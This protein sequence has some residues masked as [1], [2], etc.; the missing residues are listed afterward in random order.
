MT[1]L[2]RRLA[3]HTQT[4]ADVGESLG[5]GGGRARD[6]SSSNVK[7]TTT[8]DPEQIITD[9][10]LRSGPG[11]AEQKTISYKAKAKHITH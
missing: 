9:G 11:G 7:L 6:T 1:E 10:P 5:H 8:S 2:L 4:S 3:R